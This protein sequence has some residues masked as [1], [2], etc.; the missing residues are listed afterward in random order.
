MKSVALIPG[1]GLCTMLT[2][3][4]IGLKLGGVID[5]SWWWVLCPLWGPWVAVG[6]TLAVLFLLAG[7]FSLMEFQW[8]RK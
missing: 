7:L 5:W 2:V 3:L 6:G 4:F 1:A 8:R